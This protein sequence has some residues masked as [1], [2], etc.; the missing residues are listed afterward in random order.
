MIGNEADIQVVDSTPDPENSQ[1]ELIAKM[2]AKRLTE[3]YPEHLWM[4]GWAP[5][6]TLVI[7]NM[8]IAD[9][10]Y[11]YT[12]DAARAATISELERC[13][14]MGGG[15]LL[16]RCGVARGRWDGQFMELQDKSYGGVGQSRDR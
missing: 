6:M 5:G 2:A 13:I 1:M 4:V 9:G 14:V 8:A 15:E 3:H 16:E 10:R 11:G 12:V 7:K